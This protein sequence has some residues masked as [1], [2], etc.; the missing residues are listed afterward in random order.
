MKIVLA[1]VGTRMP[2]WVDE[3]CQEY[4]RRVR[5]TCTLEFIEIP[6]AKRGKHADLVRIAEQEAE[7]LQKRLSGVPTVVALDRGGKTIS[8]RG[9]AEFM[10]LRIDQSED[11]AL[12]I[13]GPEGLSDRFLQRSDQVW[14][15]SA[16]T[17]AHPVARVVIAEQIYRAW[18]MIQGLP[19]HRG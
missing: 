8:T 1:A 13:G 12:V 17:M 18:S 5:G 2:A 19:Y 3:A 10:Q 4:A 16:M 11:F 7:Q 14:S 6:A 15:L 9:L